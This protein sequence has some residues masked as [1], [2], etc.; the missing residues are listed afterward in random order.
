M[1]TNLY[2]CRIALAF[3]D[4]RVGIIDISK[5]SATNVFIEN[6]ISRVDASVLSLVWSPDS[7]KLAF[8][9][10]EGRVSEI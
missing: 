5:M 7:K 1:I 4:R 8:G 3:S 9:T 2:F 10:L 6:Y